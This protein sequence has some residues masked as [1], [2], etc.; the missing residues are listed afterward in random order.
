MPPRFASVSIHN[1]GDT[2][3]LVLLNG[4]RLALFGGQTLTGFAAGMDLNAIPISAIQRVEV[5]TDGASSLY[6]ADAI[7]GVVN[8]ITVSN[9]TQGDL[10]IGGS[11][12]SGG[13][14]EG[15][16]SVQKGFGAL[17]KDGFN[18]IFTAAYDKRTQLNSLER[19]YAKTG[20]IFFSANGKNYR[21][22]QFSTRPIPANATDDQGQLISP[23]QKTTGVC[24]DRTFR[25][26]RPT[27][28]AAWLTITGFDFVGEPK[29]IRSRARYGRRVRHIARG[30]P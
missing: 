1:I 24:P 16:I 2:R 18:A 8:F 6:G 3:T 20:K 30:R 12:P 25:V 4:R 23:Y 5:L 13:A 29:S 27:T 17:D 19:D 10:T 14:R 21:I 15:R 28:T 9:S 26:I 7:A 11:W 22:Q